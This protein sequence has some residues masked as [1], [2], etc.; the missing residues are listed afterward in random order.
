M[1]LNIFGTGD[2]S[3]KV[4]VY[5]VCRQFTKKDY[6]DKIKKKIV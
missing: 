2:W 1:V 6:I 5:K 4:D 3:W